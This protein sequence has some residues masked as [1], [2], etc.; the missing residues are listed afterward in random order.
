MNRNLMAILALSTLLGDGCVFD[1]GLDIQTMTGTVVVPRAAATRTF[2]GE[3]DVEQEITD[4][5]LIGPVYLGLFSGVENGIER[6][7][8]PSVGPA[9]Q[10][11]RIGD[12]YPYGGTTV[13]DYQFACVEFLSCKVVSGRYQDFNEIISWFNDTVGET[14]TDSVGLPI[15]TGEYLRQRC[16]EILEVTSDDELRLTNTRDRNEDGTIDAKDL[17][18]VENAA[19]D[20]EAKFTIYN[21]EYVDG[22]S[23]WGWMDAP[24]ETS[25]KFS[26]CDPSSGYVYREYNEN[27]SS[28]RAW[29][30]LLNRP[31]DVITVGDWVSEDPHIYQ[32]IDDDVSLTLGYMVGQQ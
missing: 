12:T 6:Y 28:G 13:G 15:E 23:L 1:E 31:S 17:D 30:D 11:G 19:G 9:Y 26:S 32:S 18:F 16:Y 2:V 7:P 21:Q 25:Y 29:R 8:H 27:F 20:F 14:V 24:S 5:K 10:A 3:D 22:F 4:V